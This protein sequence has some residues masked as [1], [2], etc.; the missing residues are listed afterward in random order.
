MRKWVNNIKHYVNR[1]YEK[2]VVIISVGAKVDTR[3]VQ[4]HRL[5]KGFNL[6]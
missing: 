2:S 4:L 3:D 1:D 6:D 5:L